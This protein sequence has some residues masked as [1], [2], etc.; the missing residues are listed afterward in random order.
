MQFIFSKHETEKSY[1]SPILRSSS[2]SGMLTVEAAILVPLIIIFSVAMIMVMLFEFQETLVSISLHQQG[3]T[4]TNFVTTEILKPETL[5]V[6]G[7]HTV[8]NEGLESKGILGVRSLYLSATLTPEKVRWTKM[9]TKNF[10]GFFL[11]VPL[12][13]SLYL[14]RGQMFEQPEGMP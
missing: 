14:L 10:S 13:V 7:G 11:S 12:P 9:K 3:I 6:V 4:R 1:I 5:P 2:E 8:W